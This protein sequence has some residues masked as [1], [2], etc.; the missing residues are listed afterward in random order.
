MTDID[1][2]IKTIIENCGNTMFVKFT[3]EPILCTVVG[4]GIQKNKV[5]PSEDELY[6]LAYKKS[7]SSKAMYATE[8]LALA[9][10]CPFLTY[11]YTRSTAPLR[12]ID[13]KTLWIV[14]LVYYVIRVIFTCIKAYM[15]SSSVQL[16]KK[17]KK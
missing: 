14:V 6:V 1:N 10:I 9:F 8:F 5:K 15:Q 12:D 11:W 17:K 4:W 3:S 7:N 2:G 16:K 13:P